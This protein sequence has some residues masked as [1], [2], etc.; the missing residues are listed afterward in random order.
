MKPNIRVYVN[1]EEYAQL[2]ELAERS[3]VSLSGLVGRFVRTGLE[4]LQLSDEIRPIHPLDVKNYEI[5]RFHVGLPKQ[6]LERLNEYAEKNRMSR[7]RYI[8]SI[9]MCHA[10]AE[11]VYDR[12]AQAF[13]SRSIERVNSLATAVNLLRASFE[14]SGEIPNTCMEELSTIHNLCETILRELNTMRLANVERWK[15]K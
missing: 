8:E 3:G 15:I 9:L 12:E 7:V 13:A 2:S 14:K 6:Y 10:S 5:A 4:G 1:D 11:P